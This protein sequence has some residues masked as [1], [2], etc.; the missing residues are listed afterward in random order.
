MNVSST[1]GHT[2]APVAVG[3]YVVLRRSRSSGQ[4]KSPGV[5]AVRL[6][7]GC[8]TRGVQPVGEAD[9]SLGVGAEGDFQYTP[10]P[11]RE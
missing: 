4:L 9:L 10:C 3:G 1:D 8:N 2:A 5:R 6:Q 11:A 7:T